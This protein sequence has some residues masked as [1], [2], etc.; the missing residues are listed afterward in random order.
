MFF[1]FFWWVFATVAME[2]FGDKGF[3]RAKPP[4]KVVSHVTDLKI[5]KIY[6]QT[7]LD[8]KDRTDVSTTPLPT[9]TDFTI[10]KLYASHMA[11]NGVEGVLVHNEHKLTGEKYITF[12]VEGTWS[13]IQ[14]RLN[15]ILHEFRDSYK[16]AYPDSIPAVAHRPRPIET[17]ST[18]P[19]VP[20]A[21]AQTV[22]RLVAAKRL[23]QLVNADI[24]SAKNKK[25][26]ISDLVGLRS[27]MGRLLQKAFCPTPFNQEDPSINPLQVQI[28]AL[29]ALLEEIAEYKAGVVSARNQ[30]SSLDRGWL[31]IKLKQIEATAEK[32][33]QPSEYMK[34]LPSGRS[35]FH[36]DTLNIY[37]DDQLTKIN[38]TLKEEEAK[39]AP[40]RE[41]Q[42]RQLADERKKKLAEEQS[43]YDAEHEDLKQAH[44]AL[45]DAIQA[46]RKTHDPGF[47]DGV[48]NY[49]VC[50]EH[51]GEEDFGMGGLF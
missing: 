39:A 35:F 40:E 50:A 51:A 29:A 46:L 36:L 28:R 6:A 20:A 38:G 42:A 24:A 37:I 22:S 45:N 23:I 18:P 43:K 7:V 21:A 13:G 34:K 3:F 48:K 27:E 1:G 47:K 4:H 33:L 14:S 12:I 9:C 19:V 11:N 5:A 49:S 32:L 2:S 44:N 31:P 25:A 30:G 8:A 17:R 41:K 10:S 26:P 15:Q 16:Q